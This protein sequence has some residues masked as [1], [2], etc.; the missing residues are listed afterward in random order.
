MIEMMLLGLVRIARAWNRL[1]A[2]GGGSPIIRP[3]RAAARH[4]AGWTING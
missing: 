1:T 2:R 3:Q 4:L